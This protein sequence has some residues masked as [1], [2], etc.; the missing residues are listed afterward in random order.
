METV[1]GHFDGNVV[2]LDEPAP[3]SHAIPVTV[4]F[5]DKHSQRKGNRAIPL[6]MGTHTSD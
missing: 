3:T 6:L 4:T 1:R 2:V 5:P